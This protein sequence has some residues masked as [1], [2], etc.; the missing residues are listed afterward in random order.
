MNF[1]QNHSQ[2]RP[3]RALLTGR[4]SHTG[5]FKSISKDLLDPTAWKDTSKDTHKYKK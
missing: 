1:K 2:H 4:L 5:H 3:C